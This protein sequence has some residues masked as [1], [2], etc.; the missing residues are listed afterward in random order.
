[1]PKLNTKQQK[2]AH[3]TAVE[4]RK[5]KIENQ[6]LRDANDAR[7]VDDILSALTQ[8]DETKARDIIKHSG[9]LCHLINRKADE[10]I[11]CRYAVHAMVIALKNADCKSILNDMTDDEILAWGICI[12]IAK[13]HAYPE[14]KEIDS[15]SRLTREYREKLESHQTTDRSGVDSNGNAIYVKRDLTQDEMELIKRKLRTWSIYEQIIPQETWNKAVA[16][17]ERWADAIDTFKREPQQISTESAKTAETDELWTMDQ[18]A[19]FL[20]ITKAQVIHKNKSVPADKKALW[21]DGNT[22]SRRFISKYKDEYKAWSDARA[23]ENKAKKTAKPVVTKPD[24]KPAKQHSKK[25]MLDVRAMDAFLAKLVEMCEKARSD[26]EA[27]E[28]KREAVAAQITAA[29]QNTAN[30][31]ERKIEKLTKKLVK[32]NA[33]IKQHRSVVEHLER[34]QSLVDKKNQALDAKN[35]AARALRDAE[36]SFN[37]VVEE[38]AAFIESAIQHKK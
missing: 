30:T 22:R 14:Q 1:M 19:E 33:E 20:G 21:F 29:A 9:A 34:A 12:E 11:T 16:E 5:K 8:I 7:R 13:S 26:K 18:L 23:N 36:E 2:L 17:L 25:T 38:I 32:L 15:V 4:E 37:S 24:P 28:Q 35:A 6:L 10:G 3:Q 31:D 27:A